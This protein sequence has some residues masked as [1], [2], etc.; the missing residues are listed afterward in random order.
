MPTSYWD[1]VCFGTVIVYTRTSCDQFHAA[2]TGR[3]VANLTVL[4]WVV[5]CLGG[6]SRTEFGKLIYSKC[7]TKIVREQI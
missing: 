7:C 4:S 2:Q 5:T 6:P 1:C 3:Q